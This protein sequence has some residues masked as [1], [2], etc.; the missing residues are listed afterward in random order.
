MSQV[1]SFFGT[2]NDTFI[3]D[4]D[5][6][7]GLGSFMV[8]GFENSRNSGIH[9]K[10]LNFVDYNDNKFTLSGTA[11]TLIFNEV[12]TDFNDSS[13]QRGFYNKFMTRWSSLIGR[14]IFVASFSTFTNVP[15]L[16]L[17]D[18][19]IISDYMFD[20]SL[21]EFLINEYKEF[22]I[23]VGISEEILD[24]INFL[25]YKTYPKEDVF[26]EANLN[27]CF[28]VFKPLNFELDDNEEI[29]VSFGN[30]FNGPLDIDFFKQEIY[31]GED[32][33]FFSNTDYV[34]AGIPR[35]LQNAVVPKIVK[36][37][38]FP[39]E[40]P[41]EYFSSVFGF[42]TNIL[43]D[44]QRE[45]IDT[46]QTNNFDLFLEIKSGSLNKSLLGSTK[47]CQGYQII[48]NESVEFCKVVS[49]TDKY[50]PDNRLFSTS[51]LV[52]ITTENVYNSTLSTKDSFTY[53]GVL[54]FGPSKFYNWVTDSD[55]EYILIK[56][57]RT[58]PFEIQVS[59]YISGLSGPTSH[60]SSVTGK[61]TMELKFT[62]IVNPLIYNNFQATWR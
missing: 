25:E 44:T 61:L 54:Y 37:Q 42:L 17:K 24:N 36:E 55:R 16:T 3:V 34:D 46:M 31:V 48:N 26:S 18:V 35:F 33:S 29:T 11:S 13:V 9:V 41:V 20:Q 2:V 57:D 56:P 28:T 43:F 10:Q 50:L 23:D 49:H 14:Y 19:V 7:N 30:T 15:S 12:R 32:R 39:I 4:I 40:D 6:N 38:V 21:N 5:I 58:N 60:T 27:L 59:K 1:S 52:L 62:N 8:P 53:D 47:L 45:L 51:D 22:A